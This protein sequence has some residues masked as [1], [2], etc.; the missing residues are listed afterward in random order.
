MVMA[1]VREETGVFC[2][3]VGAVTR[4]VGTLTQSVK[5]TSC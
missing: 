3:A 5:G 2:V 4:T 1:T